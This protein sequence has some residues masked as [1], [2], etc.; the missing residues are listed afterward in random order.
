MAKFLDHH[1]SMPM[2]P[3][4][5]QAVKEKIKSGKPD[6]NGAIGVNVLVGEK[7]T[8]CITDAPNASAVHKAHQLIGIDLGPGDVTEVQALV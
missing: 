2:P 7:D 5:A 8:W 1:P 4:M 3:E 6:E